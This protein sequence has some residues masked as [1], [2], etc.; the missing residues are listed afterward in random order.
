MNIEYYIANFYYTYFKSISIIEWLFI[1][2]ITFLIIFIC[3]K[4]MKYVNKTIT[5][6]TVVNLSVL[7]MY[8][9][10][11]L[12]VTVINRPIYE[13]NIELKLFWTYYEYFL[14]KDDRL[15][16]TICVNIGMFI[17]IGVLLNIL[18]SCKSS[19]TIAFL[20]SLFIEAL[21]LITRRGV[22][23]VDDLF[24]NVLGA[25]IGCLFSCCMVKIFR[26]FLRSRIKK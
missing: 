13:K 26:L 19:I 20:G 9:L 1:I 4:Y 24:N 14:T 21:Q 25:L 12:V 3:G 23:E 5:L 8:Y 10:M 11:L 22:F 18:I 7:I 6:L 15:L 16:Q 17:P 2:G